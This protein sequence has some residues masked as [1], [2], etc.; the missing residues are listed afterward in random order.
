L[1]EKVQNKT[2]TYINI[3]KFIEII[4]QQVKCLGVMATLDMVVG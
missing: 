3:Y 4:S 1:V 2:S